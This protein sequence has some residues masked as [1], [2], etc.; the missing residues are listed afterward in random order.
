MKKEGSPRKDEEWQIKGRLGEWG[1]VG[2]SGLEE[3][4]R[5]WGSVAAVEGD[6]AV[7]R[8]VRCHQEGRALQ[9]N[10]EFSPHADFLAAAF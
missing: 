6:R 4:Q 3:G 10:E 9:R 8:T 7:L 5:S 2:D 1:T